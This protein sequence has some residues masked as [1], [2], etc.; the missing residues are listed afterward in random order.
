MKIIINTEVTP[1]QVQRI[2]LVSDDIQIVQPQD[3][4]AQLKEIVDTNVILGGFNRAL[5]ENAQQLKWVQVLGAGVDGVI[6]PEFVESDVILT[7]AKGLVGPH[8]ADQ[9]WALL[10]GLLRGIGRAV[11]ERTWENRMSIR[12]ETW[13]TRRMY[14]RHRRARRY[15]D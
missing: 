14:A 3:N 8:L 9:T 1:E 10:L 5:F 6:F 2:Q 7:S 11:R 4:E 13:E 12:E 15:R